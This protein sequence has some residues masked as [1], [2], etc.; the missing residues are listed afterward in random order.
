MAK[1]S[2]GTERLDLL[3]TEHRLILASTAKTGRARMA[4]TQLLGGKM[5]KGAD[6][7]GKKGTLDRLSQMS[8]D[9]I[10]K[11]N[12]A[13]FE[14]DYDKLVTLIV[15]AQT[16]WEVRIT[17]VTDRDKFLLEA[18]RTAL[19]GVKELMFSLLGQKLDF[20]L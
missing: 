12:S 14:I 3:M 8:P 18:S 4:L 9:E 15:G 1:L 10:L 16:R 11:M 6:G 7:Q 17:L 2:H 5:A 20:R 19:N 13:N